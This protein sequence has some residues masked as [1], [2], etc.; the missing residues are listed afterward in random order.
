MTDN[1]D[2][3]IDLIEQLKRRHEQA[4]DFLKEG[5]AIR[6]REENFIAV[7]SDLQKKVEQYG[8]EQY[9]KGKKEEQHTVNTLVTNLNRLQ[10]QVAD[11]ECQAIDVLRDRERIKQAFAFYED[12]STRLIIIKGADLFSI[13]DKE[14]KK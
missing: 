13:I 11:L 12:K 1:Q 5:T 8:R 14:D 3:I 2:G 6:G 4:R 10:N 7:L 9:E